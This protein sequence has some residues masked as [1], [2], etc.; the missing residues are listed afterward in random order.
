M[1]VQTIMARPEKEELKKI[2]TLV[3]EALRGLKMDETGYIECAKH[4]FEEVRNY[5][6]AYA[7]HK[8]KWFDIKYDPNSKIITAVR[9]IPPPWETIPQKDEMEED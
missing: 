5:L 6:V 1:E 2:S 7:F 8:H 4:P 9:S 3:H